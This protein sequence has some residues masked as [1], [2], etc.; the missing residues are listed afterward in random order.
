M[1]EQFPK[2]KIVVSRCIEFA[3]CRYNGAMIPSEVV[4][5]LT[6]HVEF[7][8][9]C[10][11][12]EIGLG[13]PRDTIRVV[14]SGARLKLMQPTTG[15]DVTV[16]MQ[17]FVGSFLGSLSDVDGFILKFR[18]PSCGLKEVKIYPGPDARTTA[19]K[20]PGFFGGAVL[21]RF[22]QLAVEDEGRL[23]NFRIREHFLTRIFAF[24]AF[25]EAARVGSMRVL[26][27]F[28]ACNK[29]LLMAYNQKEMR[30]LGRLV[31]NLEK[32]PTRQVFAE[33]E[34][35]LRAALAAAPRYTSCINVLMHA[36]GYFSEG[37][38]KK[39]K[40]FF[41]AALEEYRGTRTPLS[42]P[43]GII[44]SYIVRFDEGYLAQQSFFKPYPDEL[45]EIT[46]SGKGRDL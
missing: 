1:P 25:R 9:V 34:E 23:T 41:L 22:P 36:L 38:A 15:K 14:K 44:K 5:S 3:S 33:Y 6:P 19:E 46:D 18:S 16:S 24:A 17:R 31:A 26:V 42:V 40:A 4:R 35:H 45:V 27:E 2:P 39:E 13:V 8:P 21:E 32:K 20:G 12:V 7:V 29:L 30:Y 37:L 10:P 43:V 28:Q 11:E